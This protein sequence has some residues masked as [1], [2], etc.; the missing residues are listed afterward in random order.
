M[1]PET[2]SVWLVEILHSY[3]LWHLGEILGIS[4]YKIWDTFTVLKGDRYAW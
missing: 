4:S 1:A 2:E 3:K